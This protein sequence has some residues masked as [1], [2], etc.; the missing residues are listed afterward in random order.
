MINRWDPFADIARLHDEFSRFAVRQEA[1]VPRG[2]WAVAVDIAEDE[3]AIHL[4]ADVPGLRSEDLQLSVENDVLTL[5]GERR[6]EKEDKK[7]NY[8]RSERV[9]GAFTR[10]FSLP[11][12]V[13]GEKISADLTDGVLTVRLPKRTA[14]EPKRIEVRTGGTR[15]DETKTKPS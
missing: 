3:S 2:P 9:Y 1:A 4:R 7:E 6:F 5:K 12:H 10:S 8:L 13:D 15:F 11:K 14:P